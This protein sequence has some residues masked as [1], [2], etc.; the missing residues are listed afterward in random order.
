MYALHIIDTGR[1]FVAGGGAGGAGM[2]MD[3]G[4]EKTT[5]TDREGATRPPVRSGL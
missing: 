1:V 2:Y 5:A 4:I 3:A